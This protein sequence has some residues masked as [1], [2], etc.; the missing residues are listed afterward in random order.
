[1]V[2]EKARNFIM[3][4]ANTISMLYRATLWL[5]VAGY[6]AVT[7]QTNAANFA[8]KGFNATMK[9]NPFGLFLTVITAVVTAVVLFSKETNTAAKAQKN[10]NEVTK[11][12]VKNAS[13]EIGKLDKLYKAATNAAAGKDAQRK[14]AEELQRLYPQIF[15][16]IDKEI[17]MNG[18]ARD[19]YLKVREAI[20]ATSKAKAAQAEIDKINAQYLAEEEKIKQRMLEEAKRARTAGGSQTVQA[21]PTGAVVTTTSSTENREIAKH[22]FREETK[23]LVNLYKERNAA[24][25]PYIKYT[26]KENAKGGILS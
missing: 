8:M 18:K 6:S 19:S 11:E 22:R 26:E 24:L 10:L 23:N 12:G 1:M 20:I 5:L 2:V 7:G 25:D 15:G 21:G 13:E 3:G 4:A 9:M 14:A 16:N 17:I